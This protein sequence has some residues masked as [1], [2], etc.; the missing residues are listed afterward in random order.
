[1]SQGDDEGVDDVSEIVAP[2]GSP[3]AVAVVGARD[4]EASLR[5][6]VD[7]IGL[8]AG[9]ETAWSGEAF[10][11]LWQLPA[12]ARARCRMLGAGASPVGRILLVEFEERSLP[13]GTV[14]ETI[15]TRAD[16]QCFGLANLNFYDADI[17]ATTARLRAAGFAFWSD[18]TQHSL[19]AGVGNP[20]EVL[21]DGPDGVAINLVELAS[22]DPNTRIGQMRAY[23]ERHGRTRTGFTPVVTT[24]HVVR[25]IPRARAFYERVLKMGALIDEVMSADRVNLFLR[26]PQ[27]ARTHITFMQGNHMFGKVALGEPLN[28]AESCTDLVPRAHAPNVGYLAQAFELPGAAAFEAAERACRELDVEF[29]GAPQ[30]GELPGLGSRRH[31][32]VRN[33]GSGALQWLLGP[34]S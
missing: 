20:I 13:P 28:Y 19:T 10:E 24:S 9:P 30:T 8:D 5:F 34:A 6:Y 29:V 12:G 4:L 26:L 15:A 1:M 7:V 17:R 25:S 33:P 18:P 27:G 21:F 2:Q 23:V 11:R 14:R 31:V 16:S 22:T 3:L 32:M